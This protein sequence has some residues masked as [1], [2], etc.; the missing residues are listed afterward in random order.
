MT[1]LIEAEI[2]IRKP[3]AYYFLSPSDCLRVRIMTVYGVD[4][5]A[6]HAYK[7]LRYNESSFIVKNTSVEHIF[8]LQEYQ[9]L[10]IEYQVADRST[11]RRSGSTWT[12]ENFLTAGATSWAITQKIHETGMLR[13]TYLGYDFEFL[14]LIPLST[15]DLKQLTDKLAKDFQVNIPTKSAHDPYIIAAFYCELWKK[16]MEENRQIVQVQKKPKPIR[17]IV[18][19]GEKE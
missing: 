6:P 12:P 3:K 13:A 8:L 1:E 16:G 11:Y 10:L 9:L 7:M 4:W 18:I 19:R 17:K 14:N 5:S 15:D 2:R